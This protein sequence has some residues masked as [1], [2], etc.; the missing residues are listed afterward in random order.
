[1][2]DLGWCAVF[3]VLLMAFLG[4]EMSL[5]EDIQA[6]L[7]MIDDNSKKETLKDSDMQNE[8]G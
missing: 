2:N 4:S 1:M 5:Y 3:L 8:D 6:C 7:K